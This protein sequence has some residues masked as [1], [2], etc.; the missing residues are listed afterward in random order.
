MQQ[1]RK[2]SKQDTDQNDFS[3]FHHILKDDE[4]PQSERSE[5]R[6]AKEAQ[7]LLGAGTASTSRTIGFAS[8][9]ILSRPETVRKRL[10]DELRETMKQWPSRVPTWTEL[11]QL[12]YL[13]AIIK[14]SLR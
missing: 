7:T 6:L 13:Q 10:E 2:A 8:Y 9:Y 4:L 3:L 14:E 5:E 11:E 1:I 12:P